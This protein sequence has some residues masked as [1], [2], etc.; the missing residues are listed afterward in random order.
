MIFKEY[1]IN[2]RT[3]NSKETLLFFLIPE[4]HISVIERYSEA[5][6]QMST[7]ECHYN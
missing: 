1:Y 5:H 7:I 2:F 3:A 6:K 4:I